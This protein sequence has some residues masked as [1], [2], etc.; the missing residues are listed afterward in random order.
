MLVSDQPFD[1]VYVLKA[2]RAR[3]ESWAWC[4]GRYIR[5]YIKDGN[6]WCLCVNWTR[7]T[8]SQQYPTPEALASSPHY[9]RVADTPEDARRMPWPS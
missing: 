1:G 5:Y 4:D 6:V 8:L 9:E 3:G 7:G 2:A